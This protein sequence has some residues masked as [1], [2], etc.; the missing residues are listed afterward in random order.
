[1][2]SKDLAKNTAFISLVLRVFSLLLGI[3]ALFVPFAIGLKSVVASDSGSVITNYGPAFSFIFGG[4]ISTGRVTYNTNGVSVIGTIAYVLTALSLI[5]LLAF[6]FLRTKKNAKWFILGALILSLT[7]AILA[8]SSHVNAATVLADSVLGRRSESVVATMIRNTTLQFGFW[9]ISLF[10]F[11]SA[12]FL[13]AS[14]IFDGT[15]D[16]IR[17]RITRR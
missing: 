13:I 14:F 4:V 16:E 6:F 12:S 17:A 10:G 5:S 11:L 15:I 8:I 9:G 2:K 3:G 1:M 7:S